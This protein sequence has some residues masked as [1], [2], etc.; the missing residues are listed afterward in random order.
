MPM[1]SH[2]CVILRGAGKLDNSDGTQPGLPKPVGT[3]VE[4]LDYYTHH[5]INRK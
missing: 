5:F 3:M 4:A 1:A 2:R